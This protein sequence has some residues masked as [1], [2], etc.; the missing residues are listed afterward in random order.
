MTGLDRL[1]EPAGVAQVQ[2]AIGPG[3]GRQQRVAG[4]GD[5]GFGVA[6]Q[7]VGFQEAPIVGDI[8]R[9]IQQGF[10]HLGRRRPALFGVSDQSLKIGFRFLEAPLVVLDIG[11]RS[12][13]GRVG[14]GGGLGA[15]EPPGGATEVG[16]DLGAGGRGLH[17][18]GGR[19]LGGA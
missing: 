6:E 4:D 9:Q 15:G 17:L 7:P 1:G 18:R 3:L 8:Q 14:G 2:G 10:R 19:R 13:A 5:L 11:A 12:Q 16:G